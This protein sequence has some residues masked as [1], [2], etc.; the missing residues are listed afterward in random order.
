MAQGL[1]FAYRATSL[2][3][4]EA[5]LVVAVL[6]SREKVTPRSG[7]TLPASKVAVSELKLV[8]K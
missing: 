6:R 1:V 7:L 2:K 4:T 5:V 3:S 8:K